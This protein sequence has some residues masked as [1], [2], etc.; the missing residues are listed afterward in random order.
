MPDITPT[1]HLIDDGN[2]LLAPTTVRLDTGT[3]DTPAGL[4]GVVTYRTS[5]TTFTM[6]ATEANFRQQ[7]SIITALCDGMRGTKV[8]PASPLD[9]A[10]ISETLAAFRRAN[11]NGGKS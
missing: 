4:L 5:T 10:G 2:P 11:Q 9:V 3:F 7:V 8:I 1:E 6:M